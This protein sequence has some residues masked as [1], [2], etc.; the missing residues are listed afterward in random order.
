MARL[1]EYHRQQPPAFQFSATDIPSSSTSPIFRPIFDTAIEEHLGWD[2]MEFCDVLVTLDSPQQAEE[3]G[4][5]QFTP[6]PPV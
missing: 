1:T 3:V 5:S 2:Q 6:T 4:A